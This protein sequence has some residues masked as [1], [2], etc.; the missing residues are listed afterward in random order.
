[1]FKKPFKV[2]GYNAIAGKDKKK[3][4][5]DVSKIFNPE[6]V[7]TI[8]KDETNEKIFAS[9]LQGS[10]IIIYANEKYPIFIDATSKG[11]YFPSLYLVF[12]YPDLIEAI[13]INPGV[14][15]FLAKGANLMWPGVK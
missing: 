9:K 8:F 15:S 13:E 5:I 12:A 7:E 11:D 2:S 6:V 14:E 4:K 3:L 1:M 10:K